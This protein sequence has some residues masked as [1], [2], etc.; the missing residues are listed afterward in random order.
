[1]D[2]AGPFAVGRK[3]YPYFSIPTISGLL[4]SDFD[5]DVAINGVDQSAET[6]YLNE[7]KTGRYNIGNQ[8]DGSWISTEEEHVYIV[9]TL[10]SGT[11]RNLHFFTSENQDVASLV[12]GA[13][14]SAHGDAGSF[15]LLARVAAAVLA[16]NVDFLPL[17]W[18]SAPDDILTAQIKVYTDSSCAEVLATRNVAV[19]WSGSRPTRVR[20][21]EP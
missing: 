20:I 7:W 21:V 14:L 10:P 12:W 6:Y 3:F 1:M 5:L 2:C 15:G 8:A 9:A 18:E 4:I 16:G 13:L 19:T 11:N 17:T